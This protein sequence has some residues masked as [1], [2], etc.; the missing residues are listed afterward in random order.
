MKPP[1]MTTRFPTSSRS[2]MTRAPQASNT[3]TAIS[4]MKAMKATATVV[5]TL[6]AAHLQRPFTTPYL[7]A[8]TRDDSRTGALEAT[9]RNTLRPY[10]TSPSRNAIAQ[11]RTMPISVARH[12]S[13]LT[14]V[15]AVASRGLC[16]S[17]ASCFWQFARECG[18]RY[19]LSTTLLPPKRCFLGTQVVIRS[20]TRHRS[21]RI[22]K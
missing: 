10:H 17:C 20:S 3:E 15:Q 14:P 6:S 22:T 1:T 18:M 5:Q 8:L 16:S 9:G 4:I 12:R 2:P 13:H 7:C 19:P 21:P 11:F